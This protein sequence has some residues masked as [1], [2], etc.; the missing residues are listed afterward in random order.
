MLCAATAI[1]FLPYT[2]EDSRRDAL[3]VKLVSRRRSRSSRWR[4]GG[5]SSHVDAARFDSPTE[6]RRTWTREP[7][8]GAASLPSTVGPLPPLPPP[9]RAGRHRHEELWLPAGGDEGS[10]RLTE[11]VGASSPGVASRHGGDGRVPAA[12]GDVRVQLPAVAWR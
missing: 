2:D 3:D 5:S 4:R 9:L 10:V 12:A 7:R 11:W 6:A 8:T 1:R